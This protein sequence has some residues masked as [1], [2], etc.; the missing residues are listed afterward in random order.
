MY[1]ILFFILLN[2][3]YAAGNNTG[4]GHMTDLIPPAINFVVLVSFLVFKL[5]K[6]LSNMFT[7]KAELISETL[8]RANVKS[9]EANMMLEAQQKKIGNLENEIKVIENQTKTDISNFKAQSKE[10][11]V[12]K[13]QKIKQDAIAKIEAEKKSLFQNLNMKLIDTII[14]KTKADIKGNVKTKLNVNKKI[15][16][17]IK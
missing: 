13:A 3:V 1:Q 6:P 2:N 14:A 8:E 11:T 4:H 17:E 15:S 9:K 10:E 7:K 12:I 5:K 16:Q